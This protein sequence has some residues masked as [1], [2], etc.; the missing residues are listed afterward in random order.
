MRRSL[1]ETWTSVYAGSPSVRDPGTEDVSEEQPGDR[2]HRER[3]HEPVHEQRHEQTARPAS[4]VADRSEVDLH[5]HRRD[6]QPDED[7]NRHVDLTACAELE[8]SQCLHHSGRGQAKRHADDHAE[9]DPEAQ[10]PLKDIQPP[11]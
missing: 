10:V 4:D 3:L 9:A 2:R 8:A 1:T 7:R 5:H 6:H 11:G